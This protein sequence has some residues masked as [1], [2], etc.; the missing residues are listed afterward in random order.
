MRKPSLKK[1]FRL[2]NTLEDGRKLYLST[3]GK[4]LVMPRREADF[5]TAVAGR[6]HSITI[7]EM[8]YSKD[9]QFYDHRS[10]FLER[11]EPFVRVVETR[12]EPASVAVDPGAFIIGG[13]LAS[14]VDCQFRQQQD[15]SATVLIIC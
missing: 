14:E 8:V 3:Q 1:L 15:Y 4:I 10:C 13:V 11:L 7:D 5:W 9:L 6:V 2:V 12:P